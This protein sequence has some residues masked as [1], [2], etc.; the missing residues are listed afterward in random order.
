MKN[1]ILFYSDAGSHIFDTVVFKA[2]SLSNAI[3][4][5]KIWCK[6]ANKELLGVID[7]YTFS[8]YL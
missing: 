3:S 7:G 2:K 1:Y 6:N 4:Y 5:A 8:N